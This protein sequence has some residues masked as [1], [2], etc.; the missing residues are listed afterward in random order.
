MASPQCRRTRAG[1]RLDIWPNADSRKGHHMSEHQNGRIGFQPPM[2][3]RRA[4][5]RRSTVLA[6]LI[7]TVALVISI[8]VVATA[9]TIGCGRAATLEVTQVGNNG[10]K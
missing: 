7:T 1:L 6:Q 2:L 3:K 8:A 9:V 10:R 4:L 5:R